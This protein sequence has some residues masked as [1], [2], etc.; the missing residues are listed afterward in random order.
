MDNK[1]SHKN[2]LLVP[3]DAEPG[4]KKSY[5]TINAALLMYSNKWNKEYTRLN[6]EAD[7]LLEAANSLNQSTATF[8]AGL[9]AI[10]IDLD[11][12]YAYILAHPNFGA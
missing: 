8:N 2:V 5:E 3:Q 11:S 6:Q 1:V 10:A 4:T 9:Y 7:N 12:I